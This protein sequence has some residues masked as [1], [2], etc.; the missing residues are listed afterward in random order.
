[1]QTNRLITA[2]QKQRI[3]KNKNTKKNQSKKTKHTIQMLT[4]KVHQIIISYSRHLR[5]KYA[6]QLSTGYRMNK[7]MNDKK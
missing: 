3:M 5:S 7:R 4:T 6:K 1:M 2:Q